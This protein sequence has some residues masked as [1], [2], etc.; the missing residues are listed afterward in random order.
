MYVASCTFQRNPTTD[1]RVCAVLCACQVHYPLRQRLE[2]K[3][4]TGSTV[5]TVATCPPVDACCVGATSGHCI[6]CCIVA[7]FQLSRRLTLLL[8]PSTDVLLSGVPHV[9]KAQGRPRR[10]VPV[11][12]RDHRADAD[13]HVETAV[14]VTNSC[15]VPTS[16]SSSSYT[17]LCQVPMSLCPVLFKEG[18]FGRISEH[19]NTC[20]FSIKHG[21]SGSLVR[22]PAEHVTQHSRRIVAVLL[23]VVVTLAAICAI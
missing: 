18:I 9:P 23:W 4:V 7:T 17:S 3:L 2:N 19:S 11:P 6:V 5:G 21:C 10:N 1:D 15:E 8:H 22:V 20:L 14:V 16:T 13:V 12:C